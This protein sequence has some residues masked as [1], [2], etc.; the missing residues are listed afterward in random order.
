MSRSAP[1]HWRQNKDSVADGSTY[2]HDLGVLGLHDMHVFDDLE[3][4]AGCETYAVTARRGE[5]RRT[6]ERVGRCTATIY[7]GQPLFRQAERNV[8][9]LL[10]HKGHGRPVYRLEGHRAERSELKKAEAEQARIKA[11]PRPRTAGG[12][13]WS[14]P[15]SVKSLVLPSVLSRVLEAVS[16]AD[17]LS[18]PEVSPTDSTLMAL[19]C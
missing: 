17:A 12:V 18:T 6:G 4:M 1:G 15:S 8:D 5:G 14:T 9:L 19:C 10:G 7:L 11:S 2:R 16:S 13:F 3:T